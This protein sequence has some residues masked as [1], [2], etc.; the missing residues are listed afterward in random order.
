MAKGVA[1]AFAGNLVIL[2]PWETALFLKMQLFERSEF[3]LLEN[4][5]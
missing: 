4:G 1:G 5:F 3:G 2:G